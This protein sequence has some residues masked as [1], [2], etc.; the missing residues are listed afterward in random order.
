[1]RAS[2]AQDNK[3]IFP[4]YITTYGGT[5]LKR[6]DDWV[7]LSAISTRG[8]A[9]GIWALASMVSSGP[10][11]DPA[12]SGT[13]EG[14]HIFGKLRTDT[15]GVPPLEVG[16]CDA[17]AWLTTVHAFQITPCIPFHTT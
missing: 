9:G 3:E 11:P 16:R 7:V 17:I 14:S 13:E 12:V 15:D 4:G 10:N 6:K 2:L 8:N 5:L 1:M